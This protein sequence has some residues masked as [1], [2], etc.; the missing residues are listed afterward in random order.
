MQ[1]QLNADYHTHT[2]FS[3]GTGLVEDNVLAALSVGLKRLVISDHG[4]L[5]FFGVRKKELSRY[6]AEIDRVQALYPQIELLAGVEANILDNAGNTDIPKDIR[7]YFNV[8][9]LGWHE[10][11][12]I[13]SLPGALSWGGAVMRHRLGATGNDMRR[14]N[15]EV[16]FRAMDKLSPFMITHPGRRRPIELA[17]FAEECRARGMPLE[18]NNRH[19]CITKEELE[20]IKE[21]G[22]RLLVSSD[23]HRPEHVGRAPQALALLA[24]AGAESLADNVETEEE[25]CAL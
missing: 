25:P 13:P 10:G 21:T 6:R 22:V 24:A 16:Y 2:T 14:K 18:L 3:H 17:R 9:L 7:G 19:N 4:P 23:A 15:T 20:S 8:V 12:F 5:H 1:L 11:V